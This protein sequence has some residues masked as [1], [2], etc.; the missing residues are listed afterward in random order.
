[1]S[2]I[3][4]CYSATLLLCC[5]RGGGFAALLRFGSAPGP[6]APSC[7]SGCVVRGSVEVCRFSSSKILCFPRATAKLGTTDR[8]R[9]RYRFLR[10]KRLKTLQDAPK[11]LQDAPKTAQE[12]SKTL[13]DAPR[14]PQDSIFVGFGNQNGAML[15]PKSHPEAASC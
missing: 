2:K 11:T 8:A 13:Q 9:P 6:K 14:S 7:V 5:W 4:F 3:L 12:A 15:V 10:L 1:M